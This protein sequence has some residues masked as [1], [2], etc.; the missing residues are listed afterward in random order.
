ML[1]LGDVIL[2]EI[3]F[4]D[5]YEIKNRPALVLYEEMGNI[6][7]AGITSNTK[8]KGIPISRKDGAVKD[9]IIKLNYIFTISEKMI[10]K[11]KELGLYDNSII[12]IFTDHG[13]SVGDKSGEK[14]YGVYLY[15]YTIKCFMY[16]IGKTLPKDIEV[17]KL[18]RSIERIIDILKD[19]PEVAK[20]IIEKWSTDAT[21]DRTWIIKHALRNLRK[22]NDNWALKLTHELN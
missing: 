2:C 4:T 13:S 22:Q 18:V 17:K 7:V 12:M 3:Q 1:K 14:A 11:I 10:E 8:M 9:S 6:V 15:E 20:R 19:N 16:L 21:K 5:T